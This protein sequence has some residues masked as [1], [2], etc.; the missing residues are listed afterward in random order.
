MR[1]FLIATLVVAGF[2]VA[3]FAQQSGTL[4]Y[5]L[6][7]PPTALG[8]TSFGASIGGVNGTITTTAWG[9]W[10]MT[11]DGRTFASGTYSCGGGSC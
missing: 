11:V 7:N 3:G 10:K 1:Y 5:S 6:S 8:D 2:A 4:S 9:N